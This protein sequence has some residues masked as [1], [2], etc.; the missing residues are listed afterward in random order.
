MPKSYITPDNTNWA[1]Y[2]STDLLERALGSCENERVSWKTVNEI[3]AMCEE[4]NTPERTKVVDLS[5]WKHKEND[6]FLDYVKLALLKMENFR[7]KR[8]GKFN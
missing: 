8:K 2:G 5:G 7:L 1:D 4:L 3:K 6:K